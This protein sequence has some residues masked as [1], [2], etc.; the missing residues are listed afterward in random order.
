MERSQIPRLG[1]I[2]TDLKLP[3]DRNSPPRVD[4][5]MPTRWSGTDRRRQGN[6][7]DPANEK[8]IRQGARVARDAIAAG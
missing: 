5:S 8:K 3:V 1:A 4:F 2:Y 7:R 6:H